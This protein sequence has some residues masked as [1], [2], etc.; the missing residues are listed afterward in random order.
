MKT[1]EGRTSGAAVLAEVAEVVALLA[2]PASVDGAVVVE[3]VGAVRVGP[4]LGVSL[5]VSVALAA[6]GKL[7]GGAAEVVVSGGV[8]VAAE[9]ASAELCVCEGRGASAVGEEGELPDAVLEGGGTTLPS[10]ECGAQ[11]PALATTEANSSARW[12]R[13]ARVIAAIVSAPSGC[14]FNACAMGRLSARRPSATSS[15]MSGAPVSEKCVWSSQK[16]SPTSPPVLALTSP[17]GT[18]QNPSS[19]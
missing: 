1:V 9:G 14:Y 7:A 5:G 15:A 17:P 2:T 3:G 18:G 10:S 11:L 12:R 13:K 4:A 8:W 6:E 16:Y 19:P